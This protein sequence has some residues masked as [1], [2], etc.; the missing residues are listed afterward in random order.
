[1]TDDL[2]TKTG[3]PADHQKNTTQGRQK[4]S[5]SSKKKGKSK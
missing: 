2:T 3:E 5:K 1:V 4:P